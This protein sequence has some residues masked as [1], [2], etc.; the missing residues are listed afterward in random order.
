LLE[1]FERRTGCP[2]LLNTSFNLRGE[3]IVCT[4]LDAVV[5]FIRSDLDCLVLQDWAL[6]RLALPDS[7]LERFRA[8]QGSAAMGVS[9]QVYTL[10]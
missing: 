3:P 1:A 6:D 2:V 5:C 9:D 8:P 10:L 4:P 7:W